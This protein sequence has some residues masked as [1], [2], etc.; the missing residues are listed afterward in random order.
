MEGG[1]KP[2]EHSSDWGVAVLAP[3]AESAVAGLA[4]DSVADSGAIAQGDDGAAS[5]ISGSLQGLA[6]Q[7]TLGGE[8]GL[9]GG[10]VKQPLG[11]MATHD[12]GLLDG[13][14]GQGHSHDGGDAGAGQTVRAGHGLRVLWGL[15]SPP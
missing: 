8:G 11:T 7:L 6:A 1:P 3:V 15:L 13:S 12:G 10:Q 14:L 4:V 9:T 5:S 2:P